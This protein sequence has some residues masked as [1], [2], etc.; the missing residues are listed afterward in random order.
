M[1]KRQ[2]ILFAGSALRPAAADVDRGESGAVLPQRPLAAAK[3]GLKLRAAEP[4]LPKP[5]SL[6]PR[7][8]HAIIVRTFPEPVSYTHLDVY[9]RQTQGPPDSTFLGSRETAAAPVAR[10]GRF[11]SSYFQNWYDSAGA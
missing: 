10:R 9:K 2:A 8:A 5:T 4:P 7:F 3:S 11:R 1:Y 6:G